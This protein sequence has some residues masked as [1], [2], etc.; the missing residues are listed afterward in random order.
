MKQY[1]KWIMYNRRLIATITGVLV[2][3]VACSDSA[4]TGI[5]QRSDNWV[6]LPVEQARNEGGRLVW[7][8]QLQR[9]WEFNVQAIGGESIDGALARIEVA[10][11][12]LDESLKESF[13]IDA[14]TVCQL[15]TLVSFGERGTHTLSIE[16][17]ASLK[18]VRLIPHHSSLLGSGK[19]HEA[20]LEMHESPEKQASLAWFKEARF[21]MFIH[22][23]LYSQAG[24]LWKG[25]RIEDSPYPGPKVAEWLMFAFRIPR[26]E[27]RKLSKSFNP[28]KSFAQNI[29]R[30][31]KDAGMKYVVITAKHHD[32]FALFDSACSEFDMVDA[33]P[34][35]ADAIKELYDACLVEG[36]EFGVYYSHGHDW[37]D[38]TDGN[39]ATV[40]KR[41]DA[42]GIETRHQ[43]KNLWDP[44][45]N[46][47]EDYLEGKAYPQIAE[48]LHLLPRLRIVWFDGEGLI[49]E[50]EAFRFYE[51]IYN[52]NPRVLVNRRVGY[53]FG[54]YLDAG[55]NV[56]PSADKELEK[57]WETCGTTNNSW[58][59]KEYDDDWKSTREL[60]Y[61]FI[62]IA[63]KG[64]NYLLNVGP[65]GEGQVPEQSA[66]RLR[67]VGDWLAINGDA[68]YG[69]TRWTIPHEGQ[70]E[71]RLEGTGHRAK[72]G[73]SR[74]FTTEDF[75]FTVR[76]GS[77]PAARGKVYAISL[78][79]AGDS[80]RIRSLNE[81]AGNIGEVRLL[82]SDES[83]A[84]TQNLEALE[85]DSST[86]K[87]E[88]NGFAVEVTFL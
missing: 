5:K 82:G 21:G 84:W 66:R 43:G 41:N 75:W 80:V 19:Y 13:E 44:S 72:E 27:Y 12:A 47:F 51:T 3:F 88:E 76:P 2:F 38:G 63:S 64:G 26:E 77:G 25:T 24:G 48:L 16:T 85:I 53:G 83:V 52:I 36:L 8:F 87:T 42:I 4:N 73:F 33:T 62:D 14:G 86:W 54:D 17:D 55:D 11:Q 7:D 49:T 61:Y 30:L 28:D 45:P 60:L 81:S 32:G 71:T 20:W 69:T 15:N 40:K 65:D 18:E 31:A 29:A 9:P 37:A 67:E 39:Y 70:G 22:W 58:G 35:Q 59:Y 68:I 23:G 50:K 57:Q 6:V 10:G 74:S 79:P 34:Y 1:S 78:V 56:I 46:T